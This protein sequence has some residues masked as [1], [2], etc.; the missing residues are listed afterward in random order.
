MEQNQVCLRTLR[1]AEQ[2]LE[3]LGLGNGAREAVEQ[4]ALGAV[5]FLQARFHDAH[6][7]R[8]RDQIASFHVGVGLLAQFRAGLHC[9][10]QDVAGG[11]LHRAVNLGQQFCHGSFARTRGA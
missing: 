4:E 11:N 7:Q 9:A 8:I 3:G 2:G 6:D 5:G 1:L 10:A